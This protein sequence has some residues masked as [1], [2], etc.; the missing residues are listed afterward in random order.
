MSERSKK[1][2]EKRGG[3]EEL[4]KALGQDKSKSKL[5]LLEV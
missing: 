5:E 2:R 4:K 3:V 1:L